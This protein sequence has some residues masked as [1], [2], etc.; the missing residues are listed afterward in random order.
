MYIIF[1]D[2][3]TYTKQIDSQLKNLK[4]KYFKIKN[5]V[6]AQHLGDHVIPRGKTYAVGA[7]RLVTLL[8]RNGYNVS[9]VHLNDLE[10]H[11]AACEI[12]D[13]IAFSAVCPT[14]PLCADFV[15]SHKESFPNTEFVIGGA[16]INVAAELTKQ[17]Y[18]VF[19][20]LI[21]GYEVEAAEQIVR[22]PLKRICGEYVDFSLLP[23]DISEYLINTCS[24]LGCPF[25]CTYC[26]DHLIPR[27]EISSYGFIPYFKENLKER[28]CIHFFDSVLGG[29]ESRI[30]EVCD[31][32]RK[33]DHKFLL[34]C[35]MRAELVNERTI[36]ALVS[37]GFVELRLGMESSDEE[38]LSLNNRHLSMNQ[39][40]K[41]INLLR[42]RSDI[43]VTLYS[44]LGFPGTTEKNA[45]DT[46]ELFRS[47]LS[48][49]FVDEVKNCIFVPY[50]FDNERFSPK[51]VEIIDE[52]W[53]NYDRQSKP[54]YNLKTLTSD[55][56]WEL[57]LETT[58]AI[59][60]GWMKGYNL[61]EDFLKAQPLYGEYVVENY[62]KDKR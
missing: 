42:E 2:A 49:R 43:Y 28:T 50:P 58:D 6:K 23:Y 36:D 26:Q 59:N 7:L 21:V 22:A 31:A 45:H 40:T 33:T 48:E 3:T 27:K 34:S 54:V 5:Y 56:I 32:I 53:A 1:V 29:S 25:S 19:D 52:D 39:L 47:M 18:P 37:A 55:R 20:R 38:L 24:T 14:V 11:L 44:A 16:H 15:A 17:R 10:A 61:T 41:A 51:E 12:P 60:D 4:N 8:H 13:I 46:L 30:L 57:F 35:D 62:T 9:Y